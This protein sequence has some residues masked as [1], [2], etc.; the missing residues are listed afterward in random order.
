MCEPV[1]GRG[2]GIVRGGLLLPVWWNE[3]SQC[4]RLLPGRAVN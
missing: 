4:T 1:R 3:V 2:F